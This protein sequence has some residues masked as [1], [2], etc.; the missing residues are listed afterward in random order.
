MSP[1]IQKTI[2]SG[3]LQPVTQQ[4]RLVIKKANSKPPNQGEANNLCYKN[5]EHK[6]KLKYILPILSLT[7]LEVR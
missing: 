3:P 7:S 1:D 2:I 4:V 6:C 5:E